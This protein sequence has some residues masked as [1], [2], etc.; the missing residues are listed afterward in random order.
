MSLPSRPQCNKEDLE[1][2]YLVWQMFTSL[3][4]HLLAKLTLGNYLWTLILFSS[5]IWLPWILAVAE[6]CPMGTSMGRD[7]AW[8]NEELSGWQEELGWNR[9]TWGGQ[10]LWLDLAEAMGDILLGA[11]PVETIYA[12]RRWHCFK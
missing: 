6:G 10:G 12:V 5:P 11:G 2:N 3:I 8:G 9:R 7:V 4:N 1:Y